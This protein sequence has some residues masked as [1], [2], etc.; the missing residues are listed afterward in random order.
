MPLSAIEVRNAAPKDK[1]YKLADSGGLYLLVRAGGSKLWRYDYRAA[2]KRKT[3]ALGAYPEVPLADAR[4]K[5][6]EARAVVRD[7]GDPM[8][9]RRRSDG[10]AQQ[11]FEA[12]ARLRLASRALGWSAGHVE[13]VRRRLERNIFPRFGSKPIGEVTSDDVLEALRVI[14]DRGAIEAARRVKGHVS[15]T[16]RFAKGLGL[17][18]EDPTVVITEARLLRTQPRRQHRRAMQPHEFPRFLARL[19]DSDE[20]EDTR[21]ALLLTLYCATR[22]GETRFAAADEFQELDGETPLWRIAPERMKMKLEHL[23]P[24][25]P[26]AAAIVRRRLG[27]TDGAGLLFPRKTVSGTIS[28]NTMLYALY[29]LGYHSKATVHGF[30]GS[31]STILNEQTRVDTASGLQVRLFDPDWVECQLAHVERNQV[32]GAYNAAEY[33]GPRR[34]M[35][36]W[37]ADWIDAQAALGRLLG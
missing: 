28:E 8:V 5:H 4:R 9:A 30:R 20:E 15:E 29:R 6:E 26:Q 34:A 31:F 18:G 10:G 35:M 33:L 3:M 23:V 27:R 1:D 21:D 11:S 13:R 36:R 24:L 19:A 37:W 17:V 7:G 2:G 22:T 12:V 16:F 14:E 32:R 25:A